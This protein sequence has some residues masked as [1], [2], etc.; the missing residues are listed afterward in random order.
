MSIRDI[1]GRSP[2]DLS[3]SK[4]ER[5]DL[6]TNISIQR[7]TVYVSCLECAVKQAVRN[8]SEDAI[9]CINCNADLNLDR[10]LTVENVLKWVESHEVTK[11]E[12]PSIAANQPKAIR[13]TSV[14]NVI[15]DS[16]VEISV[17]YGEEAYTPRP[18]FSFRI[19]PYTLSCK[20]RHGETIAD[21]KKRLQLQL[22]AMAVADFESKYRSFLYRVVRITEHSG[23]K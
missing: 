18:F 10:L 4:V 13:D 21:T 3:V 9:Y 7:G 6:P 14:S 16:D 11:F 5:T 23:E 20:V 22:D 12:R 2:F 17:T 1:P 15:D 19:G 8:G